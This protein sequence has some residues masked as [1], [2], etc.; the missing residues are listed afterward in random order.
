VAASPRAAGS[1]PSF[2]LRLPPPKFELIDSAPAVRAEHHFAVTRTRFAL[3][4]LTDAVA[5]LRKGRSGQ[6]LGA[7]PPPPSAASTGAP[8]PRTAPRIGLKGPTRSE[9]SLTAASSALAHK[10]G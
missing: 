6:A 2:F 9:S 10:P 3:D 1:S 4:Y 5:L 8:R 7:P